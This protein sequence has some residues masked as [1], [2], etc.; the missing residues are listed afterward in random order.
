MNRNSSR[1]QTRTM[2]RVPSTVATLG[3]LA[4]LA[5]T[6]GTARAATP[7]VSQVAPE[8]NDAVVTEQV[9][10][11]LNADPTYFFRHVDVQV[12]DG[13]VTLSGY[14]WST[15][16]IYRAERIT[17][18]VSGVTRVIDQMELERDGVTPHA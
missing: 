12:Q 13:V 7:V 3:A 1:A 18:G 11:A 17:S 6:L 4:A 16:A 5:L 15:P 14:V 8:R 10:H 2:N 9:Y